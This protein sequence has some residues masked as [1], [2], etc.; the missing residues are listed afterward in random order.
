MTYKLGGELR[1]LSHPMSFVRRQ[2]AIPVSL[3]PSDTPLN[4]PM[5]T[6]YDVTQTGIITDM[7]KGFQKAV[8]EGKKMYKEGKEM[9]KEY[10]KSKEK[11]EK[12]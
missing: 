3:A 4:R 8:K 11:N 7:K 10:K 1:A 6:D 2:V 5:R 9:Y 12:Q